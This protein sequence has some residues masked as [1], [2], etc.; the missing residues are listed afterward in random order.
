MARIAL[1]KASLNRKRADLKTY[2]RYLPSLEMKRRQLLVRL[3]RERQV[4][5]ELEDEIAVHLSWV[6]KNLPMLGC[7]D[8][9]VENLIRVTHVEIGEENVLGAHIPAFEDAGFER[10]PYGYFARPHWVDTLVVRLETV[11]RLRIRQNVTRA[12]VDALRTAVT[13][14]TQRV[15]LFEKVLIPQAQDDIHRIQVYLSDSDRAAVVR[16]KIAKAKHE[17][18]VAGAIGATIEAEPGTEAGA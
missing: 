11:A 15:N 3:S 7:H 18:T 17:K 1:N 8:I 13:K 10:I 2:A 6:E 16:S 5:G 14:V 9:P 12:R 4:L